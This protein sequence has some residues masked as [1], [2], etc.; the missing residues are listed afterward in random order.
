MSREE[1]Q[2]RYDE[3]LE[4]EVVDK[5]EELFQSIK[6]KEKKTQI[7]EYGVDCHEEFTEY[8]VIAVRKYGMMQTFEIG[9]MIKLDF[10]QDSQVK[11]VLVIDEDS[12]Y[13]YCKEV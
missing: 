6:P 12:N 10:Y 4:N 1:A 5:I 11:Q 9:E 13:Y 8:K 2:S 7:V 3:R